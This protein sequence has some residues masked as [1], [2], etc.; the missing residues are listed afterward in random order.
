MIVEIITVL[1]SFLFSLVLVPF[2]INYFKVAGI[3]T[4]D[5]HKK[6]K[7]YVP[8]SLGVPFVL[9]ITFSMLFYIFFQVFLYQN[10][11]EV[12]YIFASLLTLLLIAFAGFI[13]DINT[14]QVKVGKFSEGKAGLKRY[15]KVLLTF[16]AAI[17]LMAVMA[18]ETTMNLP[19]IGNVDFGILYSLVLVPLGVIGASNAVN[20]LDGFNGL[21]AGLGLIYTFGLGLYA[22]LHGQNVASIILFSAF[23]SLLVCFRYNF[24]PAKILSG[25]SLTYSLGSLFAIAAI[26]GNMERAALL[27]FTPFLIQGVLKFYSRIKLGK[28]ASDLGILEKDG[29]IRSKYDRIYSLTHVA[30]R[31]NLNEKQIVL[32]LML[33]QAIFTALPFIVFR[34]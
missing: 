1:V 26:I 33:I 15:Q 19:L 8:H 27:V 24:Y 11:K 4:R 14:S 30:M 12:S 31:F 22:L 10:Y 28:F 20:M 7:P 23:A 13:D 6:N 21:A 34:M 3:M 18:G 29:K 32:F 5:L 2:F 17:P 9:S 16:P 25:D